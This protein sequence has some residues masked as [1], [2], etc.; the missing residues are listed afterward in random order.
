MFSFDFSDLKDWVGEQ[1]KKFYLA[2]FMVS[3]LFVLGGLFNTGCTGY[4]FAIPFFAV[5][6]FIT[7]KNKSRWCLF[8]L[9]L[10]FMLLGVRLSSFEDNAYIFPVNGTVI[11]LPSTWYIVDYNDG[12]HFI[13]STSTRDAAAAVKNVYQVGTLS[14]EFYRVIIGYKSFCPIISSVVRDINNDKRRWI[15][16]KDDS[17]T[18]L[19]NKKIDLEAASAKSQHYDQVETLVYGN[20]VTI[21]N[22]KLAAKGNARFTSLQTSIGEWLSM[23]MYYPIFVIVFALFG[24]L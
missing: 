22:N 5:L 23:L 17:L 9:L 11:D 10:L 4:C 1:G 24:F 12:G 21:N 2:I 3:A 16:S 14:V 13:R 20:G 18:L 19:N 7:V 6:I 8:L 15:I